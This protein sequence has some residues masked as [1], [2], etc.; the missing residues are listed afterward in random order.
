[1]ISA[2]FLI[3]LSP[4]IAQPPAVAVSSPAFTGPALKIIAEADYPRF[5]ESFK[6][7]AGLI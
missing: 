3:L 2:F 5:E 1:M 7:K 4:A 6:S